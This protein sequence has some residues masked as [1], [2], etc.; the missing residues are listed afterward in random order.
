MHNQTSQVAAL[1]HR[2]TYQQRFRQP[3][4]HN[5]FVM[6]STSDYAT[7]CVIC[8]AGQRHNS[9]NTQRCHGLHSSHPGMIGYTHGSATWVYPLPSKPGWHRGDQAR[10][11]RSQPSSLQKRI[12]HHWC[13]WTCCKQSIKQLTT[14]MHWCRW[15][16]CERIRTRPHA[17]KLID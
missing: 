2:R 8:T 6:S 5:Y 16:C 1:M 12:I 4:T 13:C 15:T 9:P 17:S 14:P 11:N 10:E 7:D 3:C